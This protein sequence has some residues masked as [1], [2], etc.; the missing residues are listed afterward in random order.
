MPRFSCQSKI[1]LTIPT[2]HLESVIT[3][4]HA[5][6]AKFFQADSNLLNLIFFQVHKR[7]SEQL[8]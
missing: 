4:N 3:E 8:N 7:T 1:N 6:L 2:R 5:I